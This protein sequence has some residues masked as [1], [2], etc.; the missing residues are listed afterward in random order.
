[1]KPKEPRSKRPAKPPR[2]PYETEAATWQAYVEKKHGISLQRHPAQIELRNLVCTQAE[3][4]LIKYEMVQQEGFRAEHPIA[5]YRGILGKDY[6]IDGHTRAR[7]ALDNGDTSIAAVVL[8][9]HDAA[10]DLE[11]DDTS[12]RVGDGRERSLRRI[13]IRDRFGKGTPA[14]KRRREEL[15]K[16]GY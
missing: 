13:P 2:D 1:M 5:V 14:W 7:V 11:L 9:S 3:I 8:T 6:I 12:R 16:K 10:V 15:L 4:E